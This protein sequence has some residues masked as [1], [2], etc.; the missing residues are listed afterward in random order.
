MINLS[1]L[2]GPGQLSH[3]VM[4]VGSLTLV[5]AVISA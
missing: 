5:M 2:L 1:Q 4:N 3:I